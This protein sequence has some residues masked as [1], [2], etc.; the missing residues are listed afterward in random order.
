MRSLRVLAPS[1]LHFGLW[2]LAG[3]EGRQYGGVGAMVERPGLALAIRPADQFAAGGELAPR[4]LIFAQRWAE[5]HRL[6]LPNCQIEVV[7]SPP[8]HAGLG[9]G[10]QLALAI[11]AGLNAWCELPPQTPRELA[12][13]VGRGLRSAVGTYG[14]V[15]G[16]MIV[17]QGKLPGEP[18]SPLD[19]RLDLPAEWRFVLARP[20]NLAGL[21]GDEEA[22]AIDSLPAIAP[23]V[24]ASLVAE[25]REH[26]VPAAATADFP[27]FAASLF[28][29]GLRSGQ[30]FSARQGGPY[31]GPVLTRLVDVI[32]ELGGV[33]VGQSSWGPTLFV[34]QPRQAAAEEFVRRLGAAAAPGA[35]DLTI[36][37]PANHGAKIIASS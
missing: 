28:R 16:G 21:A 2:S 9:T 26:L 18:I 36:S 27:A 14:F 32:R 33:G 6:P 34:A 35:I 13:S 5:F 12:L 19:C 7:S 3:A 11:A 17:E 24:T 25:V 29:Y 22:A 37:S 4:V 10:T 31:N 1:R 8:E 30:C 15:L 20:T 23:E